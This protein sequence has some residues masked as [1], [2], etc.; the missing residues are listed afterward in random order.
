M[1]LSRSKNIL[2]LI[3]QEKNIGI[4]ELERLSGVSRTAISNIV[5]GKSEPSVKTCQ[6]IAK[7]LDMKVDNIFG[8]LNSYNNILEDSS[9]NKK[10]SYS[11]SKYNY[12]IKLYKNLSSHTSLQKQDYQLYKLDSFALKQIGYKAKEN[13]NENIIAI[14]MKDASMQPSI[15]KDEILF[16]DTSTKEVKDN[17]VYVFE[18]ENTL[19]IRK[20]FK[21]QNGLRAKTFGFN[22]GMLI[23]NTEDVYIFGM[24][25][26]I[27]PS[28][29]LLLV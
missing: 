11:S 12:A 24:V 16:I 27:K 26:F 18:Y 23:E 3:L 6:K 5:H 8:L 15:R 13:I 2:G 7:A 10:I 20:L 22:A 9:F 14:A 25:V 28:P 19:Y 17:K 1:I 4:R 29:N 21:E